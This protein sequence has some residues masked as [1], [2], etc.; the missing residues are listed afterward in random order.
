LRVG[1]E[2]QAFELRQD[3]SQEADWTDLRLPH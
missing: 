2:E 3:D 1:E